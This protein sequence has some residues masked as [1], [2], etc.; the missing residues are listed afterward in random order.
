MKCAK[1]EDQ[2]HLVIFPV[3]SLIFLFF[4]VHF[5]KGN[6]HTLAWVAISFSEVIVRAVLH[7]FFTRFFWPLSSL[8][9]DRPLH[10]LSVSKSVDLRNVFVSLTSSSGF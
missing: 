7:Y 4:I 8:L 10:N 2:L 9:P 1:F 6:A 3:K 5:F